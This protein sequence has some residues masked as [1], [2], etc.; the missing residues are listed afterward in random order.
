MRAALTLVCVLGVVSGARAQTTPA[1]V[2]QLL[3]QLLGTW[4][5]TSTCTD[6]AAA[7][8]CQDETVI[9]EFSRGAQAGTVRWLADKVVN[10]QRE[11]M[12]ELELTYDRAEACWKAEFDSGRLKS[13]WRLTVD[14]AHLTGSAQLLPGNQT[15]RRIDVRK[16]P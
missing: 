6:R 14:A 7:P 10:D 9:Y 8:A 16:A 1:R 15:I 13:V 12:G 4:R 2:D 3:A 5:G 11:S